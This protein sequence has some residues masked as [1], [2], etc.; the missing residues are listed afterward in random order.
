[1]L[2][3]RSQC[4]SHLFQI[5]ADRVSNKSVRTPI[6]FW[7]VAAMKLIKSLTKQSGETNC[8]SIGMC[9]K[10]ENYVST[11]EGVLWTKHLD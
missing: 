11:M 10:L 7:P 4:M 6:L 5:I 8:N 9:D 1:M 3:Q 2:I